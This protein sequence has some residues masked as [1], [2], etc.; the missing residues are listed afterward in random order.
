VRAGRTGHVRTVVDQQQGA[1]AR[2]QGP[3]RPGGR[4][5]LPAAGGLQAEL[6]QTRAAGEQRG[7]EILRGAAGVERIDDGVERRGGGGRPPRGAPAPRR[8]GAPRA[9]GFLRTALRLIPRLAA[10]RPPSSPP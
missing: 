6:K 4:E 9:A 7:G 2:G 1:G 3:E 8:G 5:Q 10:A